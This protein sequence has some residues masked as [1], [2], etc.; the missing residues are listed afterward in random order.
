VVIT[1][2]VVVVQAITLLL[3]LALEAQAVVEPV[4]STTVL[5]Q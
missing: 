2:A 1:Q 4:E 5:M 3:L